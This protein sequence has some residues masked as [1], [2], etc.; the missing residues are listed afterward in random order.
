VSIP[1]NEGESMTASPVAATSVE[2]RLA[3]LEA[4]EQLRRLAHEYC[5]GL[6]KRDPDRFLAIWTPDAVWALGGDTN[7]R[8]H[9]EIGATAAQAIW[10]SFTET[11]HWT[12]NHVVDDMSEGTARGTCDISAV[13]RDAQGRWMIASATYADTYTKY[14]GRWLISRR[15]AITHFTRALGAD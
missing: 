13:V 4:T 15:E 7:P 14:D 1:V 3:Q 6:D 5:H 11:H 8:G 9:E 2:E 12:S 10:P